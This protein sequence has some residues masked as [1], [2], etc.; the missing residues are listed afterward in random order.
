MIGILLLALFTIGCGRPSRLP[1]EM[2]SLNSIE[3]LSFE[4]LNS[5]IFTPKCAACHANFTTHAGIM[6]SGTILNKN[7]EMSSLY[8]KVASGQMPKGGL[9][10]SDTEVKAIYN[11]I[12]AGSPNLADSGLLPPI[13]G[14]P[15]NPGSGG[16]VTP[17]AGGGTNG[18]PEPTFAWLQANVFNARCVMCHRGPSSPAGYD[19]TSFTNVTGGTQV[20]AGNSASSLLWIKVNN[21]SMPPGNPL[22]AEAKQMLAQ[23]IQNGAKNDGTSSGLP[24]PLPPALPPL[25]PKFSSIMANIIATR[26]LSCHDTVQRKG[27]VVLQQYSS[28]MNEVESGRADNS[29]LYE[30]LQRNEMPASGPP[31]SFEQKETVRQWIN[32][33]AAN[34]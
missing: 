6:A 31:L 27:G 2:N 34:N 29:K 20:V 3:K 30:V 26:C 17:P 18:V 9:S 24:A 23:W 33:G 10:L 5:S 15:S 1:S 13:G 19:L 8:Q 14:G 4:S 32:M 11:W 7:P 12:S 16:I 21:N 25:E 28:L 22:N